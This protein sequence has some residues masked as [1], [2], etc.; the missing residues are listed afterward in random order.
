MWCLNG[1]SVAVASENA[2]KEE[3]EVY[4]VEVECVRANGREASCL[5]GGS[6]F[7]HGFHLLGVPG[8]ESYEDEHAHD[9]DNPVQGAAAD[10]EVHHNGY[11]KPEE[12]H[13]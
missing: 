7:C 13:W 5:V 12:S 10:E 8:G 2:Q 6:D 9:G 3:E 4:E 11:D 1:F